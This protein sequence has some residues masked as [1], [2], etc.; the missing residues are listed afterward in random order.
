[1]RKADLTRWCS[2]GACLL[3]GL[4]APTCLADPQNST[5]ESAAGAPALLQLV[6]GDRLQGRLA[7]TSRGNRLGW[8]LD[9]FVSPFEFP[10]RA[11]RSVLWTEHQASPARGA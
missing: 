4:F 6:N 5:P 1:M 10:V 2:L 3:S 8:Q 9:A 7:G 11:V